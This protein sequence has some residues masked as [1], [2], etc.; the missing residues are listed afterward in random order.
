MIRL[1]RA[2]ERFHT[3]I[4]W[5]DSWH[6]FSFGEH[7]DPQHQGFSA[8]RVINDDIIGPGGGF[9]MHGHRD[10][11][12]VTYILDGSLE[13][14][15]SLGNGSVLQRGRI[16]RMTAGR[17]IRHSE[18]NASPTEPCHLL[19]IWIEPN[20][21]SIEPGYEERDLGELPIGQ[22]RPVA[23]PDGRE[24]SA[25]IHQD[26]SILAARLNAGQSV[27]HTLSA[28]R[29]AWVHVAQGQLTLN[30][31]ALEPGDAAAIEN[32]S[33]LQFTAGPGGGEFLLFDLP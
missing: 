22:L 33:K 8:L 12:I 3:R 7:Y 10:M 2:K 18:F 29:R 16:Q 11:E 20:R 25:V 14:R 32:E 30:G 19:Q 4:D 9:G 26:A 21:K 27:Q 5:L 6:T 24:G 31:Q 13:H 28:G 17:G 15:D 1:R 23:T